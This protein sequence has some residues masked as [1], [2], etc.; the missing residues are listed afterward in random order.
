MKRFW[1][2]V[3]ICALAL[4]YTNRSALDVRPAMTRFSSTENLTA[5][6]Q[7]HKQNNIIR[8]Y[9]FL[10]S[11]GEV[12]N[13]HNEISRTPTRILTTNTLMRAQWLKS[14]KTAQTVYDKPLQTTVN[15]FKATPYPKHYF[16]FFLSTLI[17]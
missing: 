16:I 13:G 15:A 12:L 4:V 9:L 3:C 2:I 6:N 10:H 8:E 11:V 7:N 5:E 17:C 1:V 14:V